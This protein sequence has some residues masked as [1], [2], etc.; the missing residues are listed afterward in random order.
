MT[1]RARLLLA[2]LWLLPCV[3]GAQLIAV[4]PAFQP[5]KYVPLDGHERLLGWW[6]EDGGSLTIHEEAFSIAAA[7]FTINSPPQWHRNIGSFAQHLGN[8]YG[9]AAIQN[10]THDGL[11]AAF[12]TDPRYFACGCKGFFPRFG[13]AIEMSFLTYNRNG[14]KTLDLAQLSGAYG[15]SMIGTLWFP[16]HYSPLVQG[17]QGGHID[18]GVVAGIHV[19]EEFTPELR[20]LFHL[21]PPAGSADK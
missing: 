2:V 1:P 18:I 13:H 11:A 15:S 12:G 6:S 21:K 7:G 5:G 4:N 17:V 19:V 20:H 14:H 8:G 3:A 9:R 16:P 10:T